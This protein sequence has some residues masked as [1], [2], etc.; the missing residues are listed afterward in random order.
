MS[1]SVFTCA[2]RAAGAIAVASVCQVGSA[3][4]IFWVGGAN[5]NFHD[6]GNWSDAVPGPDDFAVFAAFFAG[7]NAVETT[8][9]GDVTNLGL[10]IGDLSLTL[11]LAQ[12]HYT[13]TGALVVVEGDLVIN[14][15]VLSA[16]IANVHNDGFVWVEADATLNTGVATIGGPAGSTAQVNVS[17]QWNSNTSIIVGNSGSGELNIGHDGAQSTGAG[18]QVTTA[19]L[20]LGASTNGQGTVNIGSDASLHSAAATLGVGSGSTATINIVDGGTWINTG[21]VT[22]GS[23]AG[24]AGSGQ[25]N[26]EDDGLFRTLSLNIGNN[27]VVSQENTGAIVLGDTQVDISSLEQSMQ[28]RINDGGLFIGGGGLMVTNAGELYATAGSID[29]FSSAGVAT[30]TVT[31]LGSLIEFDGGDLIVGGVHNG[32]LT[33]SAGGQVS[34]GTSVLGAGADASGIATVTGHRNGETSLWEID[35]DL[36]VGELG[37]AQLNITDGGQVSVSGHGAIGTGQGSAGHVLVS[38]RVD[39]TDQASER[40]QLEFGGNLTVGHGAGGGAAPL[41]DISATLE[42]LNG[43]RIVVGSGVGSVIVNNSGLLRGNGRIDGSVQLLGHIEPGMP[44]QKL[45][46]GG[47]LLTHAGSVIQIQ[48]SDRLAD[49]STMFPNLNPELVNELKSAGVIAVEGQAVLADGT[50]LR[51]V[52]VS[53]QATPGD[54]IIVVHAQSGGMNPAAP[55]EFDIADSFL[56]T[57]S[58][59]VIEDAGQQYLRLIAEVNEPELE[60]FLSG[61][62][63]DIAKV[64]KALAE[65]EI[66][67]LLTQIDPD[68]PEPALRPLLP[69]QHGATALHAVRTSQF[70]NSTFGLEM[71]AL[72]TGIRSG[73]PGQPDSPR[74][75]STALMDNREAIARAVHAIDNANESIALG[76][77]QTDALAGTWGGYLGGMGNW[78]RVDSGGDRIGHRA[79]V[80]GVQGGVHHHLSRDLL[81][82]VA[83]GYMWSDLKFRDGR[84]EAEVETL[85]VGPYASFTPGGGNLFIDASATWGW[86]RNEVD[87]ETMAGTASSS[88]DAYDISAFGQVGYDLP[89]HERTVLT[90]AIGVDYMHLRTESFSESGAG[91]AN[92]RLDS[93]THDSLRLRIG[94]TLSHVLEFDDTTIVP[95]IFAGWSYEFLDT[96]VDLR[97]RFAAGGPAFATRSEGVGRDSILVSGGLSAMAGT[98]MTLFVRYEGEFQS[99]RTSHAVIGGL[100]IRF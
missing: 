6:P 51:V 21:A 25:I 27:G 63:G 60:D 56:V 70:Y 98:A 12:H 39:L 85:R 76:M 65:G 37:T 86:H 5:G 100:D 44:G 42:L 30:A 7:A 14:D 89:V 74:L 54:E 8:L 19:A 29:S 49:L 31:G 68:N 13:V 95:E 73:N 87:R 10:E 55:P 50:V 88:Y 97:S 46:I 35:G 24:V 33:I 1:R 81:L 62:T 80:W 72:R 47:N 96:D 61:L 4:P 59:D 77:M 48:Y 28:D 20:L 18:G 71:A 3:A 36:T 23:L 43:G 69:T 41:S 53:G 67:S 58:P 91:D 82:G 94:A 34:S 78:D 32:S 38:G 22:A 11:N 9:G 64:G 83:A 92:L 93:R 84:G 75:F 90:P 79:T 2:A 99:D 15:G 57:W 52:K 40:S 45:T 16:A 17:G 66:F 26:V